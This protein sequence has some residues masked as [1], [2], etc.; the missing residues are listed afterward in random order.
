MRPNLPL[1]TL[2]LLATLS[3]FACKGE[4]GDEEVGETGDA[5][6]TS[7]AGTSDATES[8]DATN[9][10]DATD[11]T[12]ATDTGTDDATTGAEPP[13]SVAGCDDAS[14]FEVPAD[15]AERGPWA[16]G[17]RQVTIDGLNTEI[18][19]PAAWG[20]E[21]GQDTKTYDIRYAL[22]A[23]EQ[24]KIT[25]DKN[26][27][28]Q[29]DCY[30]QLPIDAE[31]GPYPVIVFIHGTASWRS[32]S[33]TQMT[34]WASRGFVV[35][36]S[37]HPG[38]WLADTLGL[39]CGTPGGQQDLSGDTDAVLAAI[40]NPSGELEFLAGR[41]DTTR[42]AVAGHSAGGSAA[43][44]QASKP[45]MRVSI[46]MA[47]GNPVAQG[48]ALE[49]ALFLGGMS[50]G[51]VAYTSTQNGYEASMPTKRLVGLSNAG[52][53]AFS[54]ICEIRN[55][56]GQNIL[57]IATEAGVCGAQFAGF[58]FDCDPAFLDAELA[59]DIINYSSTAVLEQVLKCVSG[60]D[61]FAD[62]QAT[63]PDVGEYLEAL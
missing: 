54:D 5:T 6:G 61:L 46:P 30:D 29:C 4:G 8:G 28:Q 1:S 37:D 17:A 12:T 48:A 19:Y 38:L 15:P 13:A 58:L 47:S 35:I 20:S 55:A 51:V 44:S 22:P 41:L 32:Q 24:D 14:F 40:A 7:D 23:S 42:L 62:F 34:H 63:Y 10:S 36:S 25:D 52:H 21:I 31:H 45:N 27:L 2:A 60:P 39:A 43:A 9:T 59:A 11:T 57:D 16:V 53:L 56:E 50:D 18:W 3:T 49:S 26:P 33:L